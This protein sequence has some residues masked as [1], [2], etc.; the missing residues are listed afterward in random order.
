MMV[1][2]CPRA[3]LNE[4]NDNSD[5]PGSFQSENQ[6]IVFHLKPDVHDR[7]DMSARYSSWPPRIAAIVVAFM[8]PKF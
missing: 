4:A 2:D 6:A 7:V 3:K 8:I 1:S 5:D